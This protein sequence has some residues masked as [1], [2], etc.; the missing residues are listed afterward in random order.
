MLVQ[1]TEFKF[2]ESSAQQWGPPPSDTEP[3]LEKSVIEED[4][5]QPDNR[6]SP[7]NSN[8]SARLRNIDGSEV[9]DG[10]QGHS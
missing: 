5:K 3:R 1:E 4:A 10:S 9:F 8:G 2:P 6:R 7:T